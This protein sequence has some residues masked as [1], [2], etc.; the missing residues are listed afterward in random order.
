[1]A[2]QPDA[3]NQ[4]LVKKRAKAF[5]SL[6]DW[7]HQM[8]LKGLL[9]LYPKDKLEKG[10]VLP[11]ILTS[12]ISFLLILVEVDPENFLKGI[13]E[14]SI[15]IL[16]NLLGFLLGGYTIL[17]GFGNAELLKETT[18]IIEGRSIS[19]FQMISLI[20]ALTIYLQAITLSIVIVAHFTLSIPIPL[21]PGLLSILYKIVPAV[22]II[23]IPILLLLLLYSILSLKDMVMNVFD[24]AQQYHLALTLE[25]LKAIAKAKAEARLP[26]ESNGKEAE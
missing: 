18:T 3:Q 23:S 2:D 20:F 26:K 22:N 16:P 13:V 9:T 14:S 5:T 1:M 21:K 6:L 7:Q 24:F 17:I 4:D 10:I 15:S 8:D 12:I 19:L 11:I 25:R